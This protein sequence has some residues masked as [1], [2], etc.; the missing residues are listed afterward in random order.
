MYLSSLL[1]SLLGA[2][3]SLLENLLQNN[4]EL[5]KMIFSLLLWVDQN[6][7]WLADLLEALMKMLSG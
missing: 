6:L 7:P 5:A 1:N 2:L 4:P 3:A